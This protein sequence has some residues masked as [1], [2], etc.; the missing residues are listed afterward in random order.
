[1]T[2]FV[3]GQTTFKARGKFFYFTSIIVAGQKTTLLKVYAPLKSGG[4]AALQTAF[5]L[6]AR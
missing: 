3:A 1:M 2:H 5:A 4:K 6:H